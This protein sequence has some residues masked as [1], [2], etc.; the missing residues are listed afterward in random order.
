MK[1]RR[2]KLAKLQKLAWAR[3]R[4]NARNPN[5]TASALVGGSQNIRCAY[6]KENHFS[7]ACQV[8]KKAAMVIVLFVGNRSTINLRATKK[9]DV[10]NYGDQRQ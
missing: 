9:T 3:C 4:A 6:C 5:L 10:G 2:R 7:A 1:L 8:V